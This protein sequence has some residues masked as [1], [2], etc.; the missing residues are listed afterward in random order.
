MPV[1]NQR[2]IDCIHC[3]IRGFSI[4]NVLSPEETIYLQGKKTHVTLNAGEILFKEG[5]YPSGFYIITS[6]KLKVSKFGHEGREQILRFAKEGNI[7]GYRISDEAYTCTATAL[8]DMHLCFIRNEVIQS[9]FKNNPELTYQFM[10]VL[11]EDLKTSDAKLMKFAQKSVRERVAESII[12]LA[13]IYGTEEDGATLNIILKRD[14]FA[15]IAGTIRET[16]TRFLSE[17]NESHIIELTGKKI[18]ILDLNKL[19]KVANAEF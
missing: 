19:Q 11:A 8:T 10:K 1:K 5:Q 7:A 13:D 2:C 6:G 12:L 17:F 15:G 14:E 4:F 16:A 9:L 18:K 3:S